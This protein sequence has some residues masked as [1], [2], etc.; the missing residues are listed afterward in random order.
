[1]NIYFA[2]S[3]RGADFEGKQAIYAAII[4]KIKEKHMLLSEHAA[5]TGKSETLNDSQIHDRD[6]NWINACD[7]VIAE[8]TAPSS[9]VGY[10]IAYAVW[11]LGLPVLCVHQQGVKVSAMLT[12]NPSIF[13]ESHTTPDEAAVI[14]DCF[15]NSST[16]WGDR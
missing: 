9:G 10:E 8:V 15:L 2:G 12:G 6:I 7:F 3:I 1:M 4:A 16:Y 13:I 5:V 14:V 11:V